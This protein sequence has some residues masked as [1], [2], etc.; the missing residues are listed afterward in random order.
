MS[1]EVQVKDFLPDY[2][3]NQVVEIARENFSG[4]RSKENA[5]TWFRGKF[6]SFPVS[7]YYVLSLQEQIGGYILWTEHGGLREEAFVELEQI[8]VRRN[9]RGY[10]FG[11]Q[12]ILQSFGALEDRLRKRGSFIKNIL[13]TTNT[14]NEAQRL[15]LKAFKELDFKLVGSY[16][17]HN[18][19][20]GDE[21]YMFFKRSA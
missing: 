5:I 16:V 9:L 6:N 1:Y 4:M 12:L 8:A 19:F 15:Y 3:M 20:K 14:A 18:L 11:L 13:V 10:G 21:L 7:E 17:V 2:E